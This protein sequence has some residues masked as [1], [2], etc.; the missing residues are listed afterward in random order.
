MP[1]DA[2]LL[3]DH[4]PAIPGMGPE[5]RVDVEGETS[6]SNSLSGLS[7]GQIPG[8]DMEPPAPEPKPTK[9]VP[10]AKPIPRNFQAQWNDSNPKKPAI[11]PTPSHT[12]MG[13]SSGGA[14]R[15]STSHS[16]IDDEEGYVLGV[17]PVAFAMEQ[18]GRAT[19]TLFGLPSGAEHCQ[20]GDQQ[21][22]DESLDGIQSLSVTNLPTP[23]AVIAGSTILPI[24]SGSELEAAVRAGEEQLVKVLTDMGFGPALDQ[25]SM[26]TAEETIELDTGA[27]AT[28]EDSR[29]TYRDHRDDE[30]D[31][32]D[33]Y[34]RS[35]TP[36]LD[37]S[38]HFRGHSGIGPT[39]T[40]GL[41]GDFPLSRGKFSP[42]KLFPFV[43]KFL[44]FCIGSCPHQNR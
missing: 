2:E 14:E 34:P 41:L 9:K 36:N 29:R 13:S 8:L 5:D 4:T 3:D 40:G 12:P 20:A 25:D 11:L 39:P 38:P 32:D 31:D 28:D 24:D 43:T 44:S 42:Y 22:G 33:A 27:S 16:A 18:L 23:T 1:E 37:D 17:D 19:L 15:G 35:R 6:H 10:Y 21:G 30:L 26:A 7:A